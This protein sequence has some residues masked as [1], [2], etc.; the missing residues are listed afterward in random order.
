MGIA[1]IQ[2][3][4][5]SGLTVITTASP[6]NNDYLKSLGADYVLPYSDPNTPAEIKKITNGTLYL[7][8]DAISEG[9]STRLLINA[10][11]SASEIPAGKKKKV[12]VVLDVQRDQLG[13]NADDVDVHMIIVGSL[14]GKEMTVY[15]LWHLPASEDDYNFGVHMYDIFERLLKD[16]KWKHQRVKVFGGLEKVSEGWEYMKAG[17]ISAEKILYHPLE[18]KA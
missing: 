12:V 1:V 13:D 6:K 11:G 17:K 4:K 9:G 8:Y 7:G 15:G 5:L 14:L 18:T 10:L 16:K 3:A 2:L